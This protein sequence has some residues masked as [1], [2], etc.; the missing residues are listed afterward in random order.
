[1]KKVKLS[2]V[3]SRLKKSKAISKVKRIKKCPVRKASDITVSKGEMIFEKFLL[4]LGFT[5]KAQHQI[6][7]KF[8]DFILEGTKILVEYDGDYWH[9]NPSKYPKGPEDNV[10]KKAIINDIYKNKLAASNGFTLIRIWESDFKEHPRSVA[11]RIKGI[12]KE[13]NELSK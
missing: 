6:G 4:D 1:M 5:P 12:I 8:F 3:K 13:V 2:T 10:Q 11:K 9:C 7:Y